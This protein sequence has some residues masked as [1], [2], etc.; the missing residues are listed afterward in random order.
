MTKKGR[1]ALQVGMNVIPQV[2]LE[3]FEVTTYITKSASLFLRSLLLRTLQLSV[4]VMEKSH[5]E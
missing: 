2:C 3:S 1:C 5:D 4:F